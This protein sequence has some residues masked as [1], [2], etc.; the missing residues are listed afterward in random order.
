ML[1]IIASMMFVCVISAMSQVA[2]PTDT[3]TVVEGS[4]PV[5]LEGLPEGTVPS[6][7]STI[8][9]AAL[10][11]IIATQLMKSFKSVKRQTTLKYTLSIATGIILSFV[12]WWLNLTAEL[13]GLQWYWVL[14]HGI[15]A[16]LAGSGCYGF[17]KSIWQYLP[18]A[19]EVDPDDE[20]F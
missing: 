10:C 18:S 8:G 4:T 12:G 13:G 5:I 1:F 15:A 6:I 9:I 3:I 19:K 17:I 7:F 14:A 20:N 2:N 11:S 16:G